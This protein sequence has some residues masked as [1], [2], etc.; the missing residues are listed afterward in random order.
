MSQVAKVQLKVFRE[1]EEIQVVE[2]EGRV[3]MLAFMGSDEHRGVLATDHNG[4]EAL[5]M[6]SN[7]VITAAATMN[8]SRTEFLRALTQVVE[9]D[10]GKPERWDVA[11]G[12]ARRLDDGFRRH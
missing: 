3:A 6:I 10:E 12:E 11:R 1:G 5:A 9:R 4:N 2:V 8:V 7:L